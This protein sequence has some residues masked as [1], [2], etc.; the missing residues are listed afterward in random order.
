MAPR[1][2]PVI[3]MPVGE[4]VGQHTGAGDRAIALKLEHPEL[5]DSKIAARVGCHPSLVSRVLAKFLGDHTQEELK[6]FQ[7]NKA[8]LFDALQLRTL[9]SITDE[10]IAKA[11]LLPRITGAA[12]L[13][14]K[15]RTIRGLA[16]QVNV[17]VL[18]DLRDAIRDMRERPAVQVI[19]NEAN[20][21][22]G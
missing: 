14:D 22:I 21:A 15:G 7:D 2:R 12:I 13:E 19:D 6:D 11:P 10:D 9:M 1:V 3:T 18:L 20:T 5:S 17:S 8:N 4:V 16:T